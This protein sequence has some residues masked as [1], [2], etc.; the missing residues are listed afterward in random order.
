[1]K[2]KKQK[3]S[4]PHFKTKKKFESMHYFD[5]FFENRS[6]TL[7]GYQLTQSFSANQFFGW[8]WRGM[9]LRS[10][11]EYRK[12]A[13]IR[14]TFTSNLVNR[15]PSYTRSGSILLSLSEDFAERLYCRNTPNTFYFLKSPS[16]HFVELTF[17]QPSIATSHLANIICCNDKENGEIWI[18]CKF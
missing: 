15:S 8:Q 2:K 4:L 5:A 10:S 11:W 17:H 6:M 3:I 13:W 12:E 9:F 14:H 7:N 18:P 16:S 1:M